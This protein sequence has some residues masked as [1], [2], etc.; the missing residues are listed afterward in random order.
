MKKGNP[1]ARRLRTALFLAA[2]AA[3]LAYGGVVAFL[4]ISENALVYVSAGEG[5]RGRPVPDTDTP[6]PWDTLRVRAGD[7]V[8]VFMLVS[9]LDADTTRPW[10]IFFHGNAGMIGSRSSVARYVLL[11][12]AGFNVL[13]PEYRGYGAA[14]S[15]GPASETG[16]YV[17]ARTAVT[18]LVDSLRVPTRRI[19]TYGW[20]LGS[21]PAARLA[22]EFDLGAVI[23]EGGFTSLPDVGA[24]L[25]PWVP[26]RTIMRNRFDNIGLAR[27]I[28]EP[29]IVFHGRRDSEIPF[30]HGEAIALAGPTAR[31]VPL[32][33][34]HDDGVM[35]DRETAL[36][37]LTTIF[38]RL[39]Q[40]VR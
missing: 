1:G 13:A 6:I 30:A 8:P 25:Y 12:D 23:T 3:L 11:R 4:A 9:R 20:S 29:W 37:E 34:E 39:S 38:S 28:T 10:A 27:R 14:V 7:G 19:I 21:G 5:R 17:D 24:E 40:T 15:S 32:D 2:G 18:Y 31:L 22:A 33:A 36:R 35:A 16:I 26:V